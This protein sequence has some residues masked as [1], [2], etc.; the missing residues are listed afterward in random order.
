MLTKNISDT[1]LLRTALSAQTASRELFS[2]QLKTHKTDP[3]VDIFLTSPKLTNYRMLSVASYGYLWAIVID[4]DQPADIWL[5]QYREALADP[6]FPDPSWTFLSKRTYHGHM[7][8]LIEAVATG[9]N[10]R[11]APQKFLQDIRA[12]LTHHFGADPGYTGH[13][14]Y[15]PDYEHFQTI[16][17]G[18]RPPTGHAEGQ[19]I[20]TDPELLNPRSLTALKTGLVSAGVW[21]SLP[22]TPVSSSSREWSRRSLDDVEIG[23]R[24]VSIFHMA[25]LDPRDPYLVV[26]EL[27]Q[28]L[29]DPL[30]LSE[31]EGIARSIDRYRAVHGYGQQA[32]KKGGPGRLTPMSD[33]ERQQKIEAGRLGGSRG[34]DAQKIA[35]ARGPRA[36]SVTRSLEAVGRHAQIKHLK[37]EGYTRREIAERLG[38]SF[39]TVKR[40]LKK[41]QD[42]PE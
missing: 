18:Q 36:A 9:P 8:W 1:S 40:A 7:I 22:H 30:P 37:A 29:A 20:L 17:A 34:T 39:T 26:H 3:L 24:N 38:V 2:V 14:T 31:A 16:Y 5:P 10:A 28:G 27:N 11:Y 25:R 4:I 15:N 33:V 12:Q 19:I 23:N 32:T 21:A 13:L 42:N 6:N 41:A 35:L